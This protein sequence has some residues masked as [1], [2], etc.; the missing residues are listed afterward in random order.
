MLSR[1]IY[2]PPPKHL[3]NQAYTAEQGCYFTMIT[4]VF[5]YDGVR[6]IIE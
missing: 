6:M 4:S 5:L 3:I 1:N 2:A